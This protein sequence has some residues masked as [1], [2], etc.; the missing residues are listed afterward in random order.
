[1]A[2][3]LHQGGKRR[4]LIRLWLV[5]GVKPSEIIRRIQA[6]AGITTNKNHLIS[7]LVQIDNEAAMSP[8]CQRLRK[9]RVTRCTEMLPTTS[10]LDTSAVAKPWKEKLQKF[11]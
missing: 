5:E 2:A 10:V 9:R 4:A 7:S 6:Q 8:T 11:L 3:A 1:M